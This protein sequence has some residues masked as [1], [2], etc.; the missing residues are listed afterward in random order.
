[1]PE[2]MTGDA[3]ISPDGR[4]RAS[5]WRRWRPGTKYALWVGANPS[6]ADGYLNDPTVVREVGFSQRMGMDWYCK[7]NV[8]DYRA[9]DSKML[10]RAG[11]APRSPTN[12]DVVAATA[13][14][15][16]CIVLAFG[17]LPL[18]IRKFALETLEV[19]RRD[20]AVLHCLGVTADGSPRH[21]LYV[22]SDTPLVEWTG[23]R[24]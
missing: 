5:L 19:L 18:F 24:T 10:L 16:R 4:Y 15:A 6:T 21:P 20:G 23:F 2:G 13:R 7:V 22:R 11:T 17:V 14:N 8:A 3:A 12:L 9:T 1:M